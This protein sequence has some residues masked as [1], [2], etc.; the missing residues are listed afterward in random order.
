MPQGY[1]R[2]SVP[3]SQ[4]HG[5]LAT[6][7]GGFPAELLPIGSQVRV[8]PAHSCITAAQFDALD[9]VRGGAVV[10]RWARIRGW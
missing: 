1:K 4:E 2:P 6:R 10:D 8:I 5:W 7:R 3:L 9:V